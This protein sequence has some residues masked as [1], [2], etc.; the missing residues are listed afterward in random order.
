MSYTIDQDV[1][2]EHWFS[3]FTDNHFGYDQIEIVPEWVSAG[4]I[5]APRVNLKVSSIEDPRGLYDEVDT[6]LGI[7]ELTELRDGINRVLRKMK[8]RECRSSGRSAAKLDNPKSS[9]TV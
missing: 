5:R 6:M 7:T 8:E 4:E 1:N 9:T 3:M 2:P